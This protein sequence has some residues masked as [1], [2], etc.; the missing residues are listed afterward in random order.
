MEQR[1]QLLEG[2]LKARTSSSTR[3]NCKI[4]SKKNYM[5]IVSAAFSDTKESL[6]QS[7]NNSNKI[8][9]LVS[10]HS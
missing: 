6:F 3:I 4:D 7:P 10:P 5:G 8:E 9:S 2:E 1:N